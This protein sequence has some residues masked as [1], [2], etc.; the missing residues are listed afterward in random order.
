M[1]IHLDLALNNTKPLYRNL[2][3]VGASYN[4]SCFKNGF[5][6]NK[7]LEK[8]YAFSDSVATT[9]NKSTK[10]KLAGVITYQCF[11]FD[12]YYVK[13]TINIRKDIHKMIDRSYSQSGRYLLIQSDQ[14]WEY[15]YNI[16]PDNKPNDFF[17][18]H[19]YL[20]EMVSQGDD[21]SQERVVHHWINFKKEKKRLKYLNQLKGFGFSIDSL[22]YKKENPYPYE[23]Q[24]S[25]KQSVRPNSIN[26]LTK[27]LSA[28]ARSSYGQYD[29]W[30]TKVIVQD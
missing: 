15:Y 8:L 17:I 24:V 4:K 5:P 29:G 11:G 14:K 23:L 7:G 12:I 6:K 26:K 21:L 25:K 27:I 16:F 22:N 19:E 10:Y 30:A 28:L 18:N 2:L 9:I 3:I 20:S 13:D 1:S